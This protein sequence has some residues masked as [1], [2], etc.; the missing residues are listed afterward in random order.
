MAFKLFTKN[1]ARLLKL[2]YAHPEQQ[3]YIQ[4]IGRIL[5]KKPGVFQRTLNNLQE[6]GVLVSEYKANARFF[7]INKNSSIYNELKKIVLKSLS[8]FIPPFLLIL[9]FYS[10]FLFAAPADL[11]SEL[12]L[13]DTLV[14]A[15]QSNLDIQKEEKGILVA[16]ADIL[17]A[18]SKFLPNLNFNAS[19]T[20]ND[21]VLAEN[22]FSGYSNDNIA[23]FSLNEA[24]YS[25]G[26][27]LA[28]FRQAQTGLKVQQETLRAK[29]LDVEFEA[30]R[31]YYGLLLA[32]ET[33]R[34]A[35]ELLGQAQAHYEDVKHKNKEGTASRFDLLQ[36]KVKVSLLVPELI[37][38][39]NSVK[40]IKAELNKLLARKVDIPLEPTE[41]LSYSLREIKEAEFFKIAYLNKPEMILKSLGVD[42]SKWSIS[43][44][45]AGYRPQVNLQANYSYRSN[46]IGNM[47]NEKHRNWD[48][49]IS[50]SV[51]IFDG[52]SSK[53]KVDAAKALYLQA[54][55]EKE[56]VGDQIAVDIR[57][58]CLDLK[59]SE[60][61]INALKDNVDEAREALKISEISYDNGVGTNLD[62]LDAQVSLGQIQ[63]NLAQAIYD[64]LMAG[65]YLDRTMGEDFVSSAERGGSAKV[66]GGKEEKNEKE[67]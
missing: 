45:K 8:V 49:G 14:I 9:T 59:E 31:L 48:A 60:N 62:V 33:E 46:N 54:N 16:K 37:K 32:Y 44:A 30:K 55:I 27:N 20:H 64:Y 66:L 65:A 26:A 41:K 40:L 50:V 1:Q 4:E 10:Y 38:A 34:I 35:R 29:K 53:A 42:L 58:A 36:S 7:Q 56:N 43:M 19:Y 13:E 39:Q 28:N 3:F 51:P 52:F 22:I 57:Q 21:K 2:F 11:K 23:G 63:N 25:G 61:I 15:L 5:G 67:S 12:S 18:V 24:L 47:I 17:D 6:N